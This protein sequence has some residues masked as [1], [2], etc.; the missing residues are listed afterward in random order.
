MLPN[1]YTFC[2]I[3]HI[4]EVP[5]S[6]PFTGLSKR[7]KKGLT[8]KK[9][10]MT[11]ESPMSVTEADLET[12]MISSLEIDG[13]VT[14]I[15]LDYWNTSSEEE[16]SASP[17]VVQSCPAKDFAK[18]V[19]SV[20]K[21]TVPALPQEPDSNEEESMLEKLLKRLFEEHTAE[22]EKNKEVEVKAAPDKD[23]I[24]SPDPQKKNLKFVTTDE[25]ERL[26]KMVQSFESNVR[27]L[28]EKRTVA[29]S[30][31]KQQHSSSASAKTT[32]NR[33]RTATLGTSTPLDTPTTPVHAPERYSGPD[34]DLIFGTGSTSRS[35]SFYFSIKWLKAFP[36]LIKQ[37]IPA[38]KFDIQ[39]FYSRMSDKFTD[40]TY[41]KDFN[42]TV[43][44]GRDYK[45][46]RCPR[47]GI[48]E[49]F[50]FLRSSV[51]D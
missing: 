48:P 7:K 42:Y 27:A 11:E 39:A 50:M 41:A 38:E 36:D 28:K 14:E 45:A 26:R 35:L 10:I 32:E 20:P 12:E 21:K 49:R 8:K 19:R 29:D 31:S 4:D 33:I 40:E 46:L 3:E 13:E 43:E 25:A 47:I 22:T 23:K 1:F 37:L 17:E 18:E 34:L 9:E 30:S 16:Y 51:D 24:S 44:W 6:V 5:F 2:F 15:E